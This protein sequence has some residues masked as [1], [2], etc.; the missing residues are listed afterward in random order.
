MMDLVLVLIVNTWSKSL[1][2]F[3]L[4]FLVSRLGLC[5]GPWIE[6]DSSPRYISDW[7][8]LVC[9]VMN[10]TG[11]RG[12]ETLLRL[13]LYS[14]FFTRYIIQHVLHR[15]FSFM[16]ICDICHL[17]EYSLYPFDGPLSITFQLKRKLSQKC[18]VLKFSC[19]EI[20][21]QNLYFPLLYAYPI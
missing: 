10:N 12:Q 11:R 9:S 3:V 14:A 21:W 18:F 16:F 17:L 1:S 20:K 6:R 13:K 7:N 4:I 8:S 15:I 2:V 19:L 5:S